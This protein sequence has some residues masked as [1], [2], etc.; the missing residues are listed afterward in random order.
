[1]ICP[2]CGSNRL[3]KR[4]FKSTSTGKKQ[5]YE[6]KVCHRRF[7][8]FTSKQRFST[9]EILSDDI[10]VITSVF[11]NVPVNQQF[12]DNL[13]LYCYTRNATFKAIPMT[14]RKVLYPEVEWPLDEHDLIREK[15]TLWGLAH[16]IADIGIDATADNP[17]GGLDLLSKGKSLI[18]GHSQ[19]QMRSLPVQRDDH[20]VILHTTGT[21]SDL[22]YTKTKAG[23]KANFNHSYSALVIER[24]GDIYHVRVLNSDDTGGFCDIDSYYCSGGV[25]PIDHVEALITG[26]EHVYVADPSVVKATYTNPD[27]ILNVLKPKTIVRHDV[28]DCF[29]ISHHH[30][31]DTFLQYSKYNTDKNS[32]EDELMKT[33]GFMVDTTP[34]YSKTLVVSSNHHDHLK[35]WLNEA[36]PKNELWNAKLFHYLTFLMLDDIDKSDELAS[37]NPFELFTKR[38]LKV[39]NIHTKIE[40]LGRNSAFKIMDIEISNHGDVGANGSRGSIAQYSKFADKV[41]IGHSHTPGINKGAYSVGTSTPKKLEYTNGP[42]SWIN[43]HCIIY[44]NGKRQLI[45]IIKGRWRKK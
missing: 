6:C 27:S 11:N 14:Y 21:I 28:L 7:V 1:M 44:P 45:N 16:I 36:N 23:E 10:Y 25:F 20:P 32:I 18:V 33:V 34:S 9:G 5:D 30:R 22:N 43:T 29:T 31:N 40:F 19:V 35:R 8:D 26:D 24:D 37:P 39:H 2:N 15:S 41:I 4:G 3:S 17:L 13:K 12:L 42:S 38:Y